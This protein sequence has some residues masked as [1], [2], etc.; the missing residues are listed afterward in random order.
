M[1]P[2]SY[3]RSVV[4]RNFVM[5]RIPVLVFS[6]YI[7]IYIYLLLPQSMEPPWNPS[8]PV[9]STS[10]RKKKP[11]CIERTGSEIC[12]IS[13]WKRILSSAA[14]SVIPK[15]SDTVF[16]FYCQSFYSN[17]RFAMLRVYIKILLAVP[18]KFFINLM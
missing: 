18:K 15:S 1:G 5:R 3:M 7:Y 11:S 16:I 14:P 17:A 6:Y 9:R 2:A 13:R 4:D 8:Q 10:V 12:V